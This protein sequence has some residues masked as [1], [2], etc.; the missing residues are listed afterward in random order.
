MGKEIRLR[1]EQMTDLKYVP[2]ETK[3]LLLHVGKEFLQP[4]TG[5]LCLSPPGVVGIRVTVRVFLG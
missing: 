1:N 5:R 2:S 3:G 4:V